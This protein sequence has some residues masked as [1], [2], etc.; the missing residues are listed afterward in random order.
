LGQVPSVLRSIFVD[1]GSTDGPNPGQWSSCPSVRV[2]GMYRTAGRSHGRRGI[3][4]MPGWP[5]SG[6]LSANR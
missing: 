1:Q 4:R 6:A 3:F 5:G 2:T